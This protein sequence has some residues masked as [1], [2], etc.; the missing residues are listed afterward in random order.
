MP[1]IVYCR[2]CKVGYAWC[3]ELPPVCPGCDA[4]AEWVTDLEP[5]PFPLTKDD[6]AFVKAVVSGATA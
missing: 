5:W 3:G 6:E 2:I 1:P 4:P